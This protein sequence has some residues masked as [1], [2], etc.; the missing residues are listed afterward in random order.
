MR[1]L[2]INKY[3]F[4]KGGADRHY[5]DVCELLE[6]NGHQVARFSMLHPK[7]EPSNWSEYFISY[8]GY[9]RNDS[10]LKE[11][12]FGIGRFFYSVEAK[13]KINRL[14]DDF[15]PE[16]VHIHNAYHQLSLATLLR[17][18]KKRNI[19]VV[20]TVHDFAVISPN[21]NLWHN[22]KFYNRGKN[23][24]FYQCLIDRCVRGS[25][26]ASMIGTL[27]GY[28]HAMLG[29]YNLVDTFIAPSQFVK[30]ILVGW[31]MPE[32]KIVVLPHFFSGQSTK[33]T[34]TEKLENPFAL[35]AGRV[36]RDKGVQVLARVFERGAGMNLLIVGAA[37][38]GYQMRDSE[39]VKYWGFR[40]KS[41]VNQLIQKATVVVSG[42]RLP[43]TFGLVALEAIAQGKPFVGFNTGAY[44]EIIEN[45]VNGYLV[46]TEEE[47]LEIVK[48]IS[49]KEIIFNH[50]EIAQRA[51]EKYHPEK[52]LR[53]LETI[54]RHP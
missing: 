51:G 30:K 53:E 44:A 38:Q 2:E 19:P 5:L 34:E 8:V 3:N 37:E 47:F 45:G 48:K 50:N 52:Y 23:G 41:E 39:K 21:Y 24:K 1:I 40:L 54:F 15:Q 13:K 49:L 6:G 28:W 33:I 18:I 29:T 46:T 42:S 11:K 27:E 16:V 22:G 12:L 31:G 25:F 36:S 10:T 9:N 26:L 20:L 43:E 17:E 32:N 4:P 35:Y 7:N 14:L